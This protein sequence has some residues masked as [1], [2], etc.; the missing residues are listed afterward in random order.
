M[1]PL[2]R[3]AAFGLSSALAFGQIQ[4]PSSTLV[5]VSVPAA[6]A[7]PVPES[8]V[9]SAI[10]DDGRRLLLTSSSDRLVANDRNAATDV[11]L[12][13][14]TAGALTLLSAA[15]TGA[16]GNDT[17]IGG[18]LSADGRHVV[19]QTRASDLLTRDSNRGWDLVGHDVESGAK[20]PISLA[21]DGPPG[22][23]ASGDPQLSTDGRFV[24]FSSE[25]TN[26]TVVT[27]RVVRAVY[28][29]DR[30]ANETVWVSDVLGA[31]GASPIRTAEAVVTHDGRVAVFVASAQSSGVFRRD[32]EEALTTELTA[33]RP[34]PLPESAPLDYGHPV[35]NRDATR[36]ACRVTFGPTNGF[37]YYR[38]TPPSVTAF[39]VGTNA[40]PASIA[41]SRLGP[42][43][44]GD[45]RYVAFV[46]PV[47]RPGTTQFVTQ[48]FR[49]DATAE[50]ATLVS[51]SLGSLDPADADAFAPQITPDGRHVAYLSCATG[52]VAGVHTAA[53]RVYWWD[54]ETGATRL[55][56]EPAAA[57]GQP[58]FVLSP[59]GA[60]LGVAAVGNGLLAVQVFETATGQTTTATLTPVLADSATG[61]GWTLAKPGGASADGRFVGLTAFAPDRTTPHAQVCVHDTQAGTREWISRGLDS[62]AGNGHPAAPSV[63]ADG[64]RLLYTSAATNLVPGDD[65]G[66]ADAFVVDLATRETRLLR[67]SALPGATPTTSAEGLLAPD[68]RH[69]LLAYSVSTGRVAILADL[70]SMTFSPPLPGSL[71]GEPQFSRQGNRLACLLRTSTPPATLHV[72]DVPEF[73]AS[74]GMQAV[75]W[76]WGGSGAQSVV[77]EKTLSGEGTRVA[78]IRGLSGGSREVVLADVASG[79]ELFVQGFATGTAPSQIGLSDDGRFLTWVAAGTGPTA[80]LQVWRAEVDT[81]SVVLVSVAA[82][83]ASG[84]NDTSIYPAIG[85]DGRYVAFASLADNLVAGDDNHVK[86]VYLRDLVG[87]QTLLLSR[88]P[89]GAPGNGWST[90]PFFSSDGS[91]LFFLSVAGDLAN[92]DLNRTVDL[93]K[94]EI[95]EPAGPLL[96]VLQRNLT[97]GAARLL[98][99]AAPGKRYQVEFKDRLSAAAW[100]ALPGT[101]TGEAPVEVGASGKTQCFFRV[102][103]VP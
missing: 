29:R 51:A 19:F 32:I 46:Q 41:A 49:W 38:T 88:R 60:W 65:N 67:P 89:D 77:W 84:R 43:I 92:G 4:T 33:R 18:A 73:V 96:V 70:D 85:P 95:L 3:F 81:K 21:P 11:F 16:S 91:S 1:R 80:G 63:S 86:D 82:D 37:L 83:G 40:V 90:T 48:V 7:V 100:Q 68:G 103:E 5:G 98:W 66:A 55:I 93:F 31:L 17:S 28:R 24:L 12:F 57:S 76:R 59:G 94:V 102:A 23:G 27:S 69:A 78:F 79:D 62:A 56:A 75:L 20:E 13:D 53:P 35:V 45:G 42:E 39:G 72:M 97:T 87:G 54:G 2:L 101:F 71:E 64:A 99:N 22:A 61:R 52:I 14:R 36:V 10:S 34:P 44:S 26:L 58:D 25:A 9:L 30:Q 15:P 50:A 74:G 8:T 6:D 47:P